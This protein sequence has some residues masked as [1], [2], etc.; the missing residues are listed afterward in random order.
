MLNGARILN[1]SGGLL[2]AKPLLASEW[3]TLWWML[4]EGTKLVSVHTTCTPFRGISLCTLGQ[5]PCAKLSGTESLLGPGRPSSPQTVSS[6]KAQ[7]RDS[8]PPGF[9]TQMVSQ[10]PGTKA[11]SILQ[12]EEGTSERLTLCPLGVGCLDLTDVHL[13]LAYNLLGT[14]FPVWELDRL[15]ERDDSEQHKVS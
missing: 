3:R 14:I 11:R 6:D 12:W 5:H 10:S 13:L 2:S 9:T 7:H 1:N 4:E 8:F 15:Q